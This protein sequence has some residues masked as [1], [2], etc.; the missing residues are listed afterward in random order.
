MKAVNELSFFDR[1]SYLILSYSLRSLI[2]STVPMRLSLKS[3]TLF[4]ANFIAYIVVISFF[5]FFFGLFFY[6]FV[7]DIALDNKLKSG[8]SKAS[9]SSIYSDPGP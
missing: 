9:F 6:F 7:S 4:F 2:A 8:G 3:A 5:L 1:Y